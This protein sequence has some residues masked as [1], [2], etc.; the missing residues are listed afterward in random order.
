MKTFFRSL[1]KNWKTSVIGIVAIASAIITTWL[2]EY[3]D[4]LNKAIGILTGLGLLAAKDG[5]KTGV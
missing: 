4:E 3:A 2:P 5:N 1:L